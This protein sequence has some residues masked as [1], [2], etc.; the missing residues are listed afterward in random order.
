MIWANEGWV[1]SVRTTFERINSTFEIRRTLE[2]VETK[3]E[4]TLPLR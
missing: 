3:C 2:T 4:H 1:N